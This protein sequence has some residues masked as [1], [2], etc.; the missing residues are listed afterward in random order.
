MVVMWHGVH[1]VCMPFAGLSGGQAGIVIM[2]CIRYLAIYLRNII[3]S[4]CRSSEP[5][6]GT[7]GVGMSG[8]GAAA[9]TIS[10]SARS[11]VS[12][13]PI[14][15]SW[16]GLGWVEGA[17]AAGTW[18]VVDAVVAAVAGATAASGRLACRAGRM[19]RAMAGTT[20]F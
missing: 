3:S 16:K 12:T 8:P 6:A 4:G 15:V 5:A 10:D 19:V 14:G 7:E 2:L 11:N 9:I 13:V 17:G 1:W 18:E 20:L